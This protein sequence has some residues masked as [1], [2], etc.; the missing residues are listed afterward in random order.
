MSW[1]TDEEFAEGRTEV[2]MLL[3][4]RSS[5]GH[6][7]YISTLQ[8]TGASQRWFPEQQRGVHAHKTDANNF[9]TYPPT[10]VREDAQT[11]KQ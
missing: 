6:L 4:M 9:W 10:R 8:L 1:K 7:D 11:H 3:M 5:L 2:V